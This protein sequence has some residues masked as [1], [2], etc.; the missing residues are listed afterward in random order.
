[1]SSSVNPQ[2]GAT[3]NT[4]DF[5]DIYSGKG[6]NSDVTG[7]AR[8][9]GGGASGG[10]G[11]QGK[12][13]TSTSHGGGGGGGAGGSLDAGGGQGGT[14]YANGDNGSNY[15][16]TPTDTTTENAEY[17]IT[18]NYGTGGAPATNGKGGF[19]YIKKLHST[20]SV[21]LD[22]GAVDSQTEGIIDCEE[23]AESTS[24]LLD[25]GSIE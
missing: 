3:G 25:L 5:S 2:S 4:T 11:A 17:G 23:V 9:Q 16:T 21:V 10:G 14:G 12:G 7:G 19:V 20:T 6:G 13:N 1:M 15:H 22:M 8:A 18:G 24:T